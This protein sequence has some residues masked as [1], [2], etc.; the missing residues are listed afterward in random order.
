MRG[1]RGTRGIWR[2][3]QVT[4]RIFEKK[5]QGIIFKVYLIHSVCKMILI[6]TEAEREWER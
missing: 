6:T 2:K 1:E 3:E 4:P 5:S